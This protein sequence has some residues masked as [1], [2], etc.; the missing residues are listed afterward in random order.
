MTFEEILHM[1]RAGRDV[2]IT[3]LDQTEQLVIRT[4]NFVLRYTPTMSED[5]DTTDDTTEG[6]S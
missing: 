4:R 6:E 2:Y 5:D 3:G 1:M